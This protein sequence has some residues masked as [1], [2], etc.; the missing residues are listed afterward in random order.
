M[1]VRSVAGILADSVLFPPFA[2]CPECAGDIRGGTVS[3]LT[4]LICRAC[5]VVWHVELGMIYRVKA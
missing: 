5:G 4:V 2:T 3:D 1:T